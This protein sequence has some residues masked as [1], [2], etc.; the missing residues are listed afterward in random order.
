MR[1]SSVIDFK[2]AGV[3][4]TFWLKGP[5][6]WRFTHSLWKLITQLR[7]VVRSS[8]VKSGCVTAPL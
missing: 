7:R 8:R 5:M 4:I 3:T 2:D 6:T 1:R